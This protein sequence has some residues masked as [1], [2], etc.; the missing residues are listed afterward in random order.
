MQHV[1]INA[2]SINQNIIDIELVLILYKLLWV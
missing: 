2:Q 1:Y